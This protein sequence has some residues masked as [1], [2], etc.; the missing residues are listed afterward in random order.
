MVGCTEGTSPHEEATEPAG[1]HPTNISLPSSAWPAAEKVTP[2]A[3]A[4]LPFVPTERMGMNFSVLE[5]I[6]P[7][8]KLPPPASLSTCVRVAK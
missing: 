5:S 7:T 6:V 8:V 4:K 2:P 1:I 3:V